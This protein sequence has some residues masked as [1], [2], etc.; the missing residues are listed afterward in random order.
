MKVTHVEVY[1]ND[2]DN[3]VEFKE[4]TCTDKGVYVETL[5]ITFD[6]LGH[7]KFDYDINKVV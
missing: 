7:L 6:E 1:Q 4:V 3:G 5:T 2:L